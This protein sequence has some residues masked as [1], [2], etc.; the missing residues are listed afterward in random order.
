MQN[1]VQGHVD[2]DGGRFLVVL[3]ADH[4]LVVH[5]QPGG[6]PDVR[7]H[8]LAHHVGRGLGQADENQIRAGRLRIDAQLLPR[9]SS[10]SLLLLLLLVDGGWNRGGRTGLDDPDLQTDVAVHG[11]GAADRV[12]AQQ[13]RG[14]GTRPALQRPLRFHDG[15]HVHR[16]RHRTQL[17]PHPGDDPTRLFDINELAPLTNAEFGLVTQSIARDC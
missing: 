8:G 3:H 16:V 15:G 7:T 2:A 5:G 13:R 1:D 10:S 4:D 6:L 11:V 17:R 9:T 14:R 12:R